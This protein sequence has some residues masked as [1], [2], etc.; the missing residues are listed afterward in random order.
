MKITDLERLMSKYRNNIVVKA[1]IRSRV[2]QY[3]Y[4]HNLPRKTKQ[5]L[6]NICGLKMIDSHSTVIAQRNKK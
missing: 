1:I 2:C 4:D 6:G 5:R 3:V